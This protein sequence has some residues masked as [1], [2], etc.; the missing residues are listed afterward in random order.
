MRGDLRRYSTFTI[1]HARCS[2]LFFS[3]QFLYLTEST[4][5]LNYEDQS[6]R[7]IIKV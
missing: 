4:A 5:S 7:Y 2:G 6:W 1:D 3:L